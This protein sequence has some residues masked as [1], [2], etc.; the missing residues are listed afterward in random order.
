[1]GAGAEE[2]MNENIS[3]AEIPEA[4]RQLLEAA[5]TGTNDVL[6]LQRCPQCGAALR[7]KYTQT[8][9]ARVDVGCMSCRFSAASEQ[10][11]SEPP[12]VAEAGP[13]VTTQGGSR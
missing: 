4:W 10:V 11:T 13:D 9:R 7:F 1:M 12:W 2:A 3:I 5:K 6:M 8:E